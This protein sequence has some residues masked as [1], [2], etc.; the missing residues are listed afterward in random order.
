MA[1][2]SLTLGVQVCMG[3]SKTVFDT[4]PLL[5]RMYLQ[6]DACESYNTMIL[7]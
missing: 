7:L 6:M 2:L 5:T 1:A 4:T 3:L